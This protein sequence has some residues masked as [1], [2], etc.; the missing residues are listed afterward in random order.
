MKYETKSKTLE[1]SKKRAKI[2][3]N[4]RKGAKLPAKSEKTY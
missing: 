1:N 3:K 2:S 4:P